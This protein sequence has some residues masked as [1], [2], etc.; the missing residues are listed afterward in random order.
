M[1]VVG[2][3]A[4][5][6]GLAA[7]AGQAIQAASSLYSFIKAYKNIH[8]T[9]E[10]VASILQALHTCLSDVRRIALHA[11]DVHGHH[12]PE[13]AEIFSSIKCCYDL[14]DQIEQ[15]LD[16][17]KSR[18]RRTIGKK[19]KIAANAGYFPSIYQQLSMQH[20]RLSTLLITATWFTNIE[21]LVAVGKL[22]ITA[23]EIQ[24]VQ[25]QST[26]QIGS[27]LASMES[28][29]HLEVAQNATSEYLLQ[30]KLDA[31]LRTTASGATQNQLAAIEAR[32]ASLQIQC[33][34]S[35]DTAQS[36]SLASISSHNVQASDPHESIALDAF[37]SSPSPTIKETTESLMTVVDTALVLRV[38]RSQIT[39]GLQPE[40][41]T[42]FA[43][44]S[45]PQKKV[46]VQ[47]LQCLRLVIWL[48]RKENYMMVASRQGPRPWPSRLLREAS[49]S[50][51]AEL[52]HEI[53]VYN[54]RYQRPQPQPAPLKTWSLAWA[55]MRA[56]IRMVCMMERK[57]EC[58]ITAIYDDLD[59]SYFTPRRKTG[60]DQCSGIKPNS[61]FG[62][63]AVAAPTPYIEAAVLTRV[64][65]IEKAI[66][67]TVPRLS[68]NL[69]M[70][71][72]VG[73]SLLDSP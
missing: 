12:H 32:L 6:A 54:M 66:N 22:N 69:L 70:V 62:V 58:A 14:F 1:A 7:L 64:W 25:I 36:D 34:Q 60:W 10:R 30:Q 2:E 26:R 15:R 55:D 53:E 50:S 33:L 45:I 35:I 11:D 44:L 59:K 68:A 73:A 38:Q 13:V 17:I 49:M 4:S 56:F 3:A 8:P 9:I 40:E 19:L 46:V 20:Q 67:D 5:I 57:L 52:T 31:I 21:T 24:D 71:E 51:S 47:Y 41:D 29:L 43:A 63:L 61:L 42:V 72:S 37:R 39:Y 23:T 27:H 48:L 28:L 18:V 65:S 16:P